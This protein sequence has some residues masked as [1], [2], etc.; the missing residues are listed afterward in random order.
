MLDQSPESTR[1]MTFT[2]LSPRLIEKPWGRRDLP[3]P[4][5]PIA[6]GGEPVGEVIFDHPD[7][8]EPALLVKYIFTSEP[9]SIQVHPDDEAARRR[10]LPRGKNEAWVIL[11]ADEGATI[12]LGLNQ[13]ASREQLRQAS[14]DGS[15]AE[16]VDWRPVRAGDVLSAPAG[17]IH[18]IGGGVSLIEVQQNVDVTYRLYDYDRPRELQLD[19]A[20]D[21]IRTEPGAPL[22]APEPIDARRMRLCRTD[23][24]VI[25]RWT[26]PIAGALRVEGGG[27][28]WL[29]PLGDGV[30]IAG[31][32]LARGGVGAV[33]GEAAITLPDGCTMLVSHTGGGVE[34]AE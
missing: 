4:H 30:T 18:A 17:T 6:P 12:G 24:F 21:V 9:L 27:D 11:G 3:P 19:D 25:E 2:R 8:A 1:T 5:G 13:P 31:E 23:D 7:G 10:G 22:P 20:L 34:L 32:P 28:A 16:L 26:G 33:S 15:I 14:L 29:A